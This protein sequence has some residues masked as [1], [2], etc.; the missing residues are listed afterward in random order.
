SAAQEALAAGQLAKASTAIGDL[1]QFDA[2]APALAGLQAEFER[3]QTQRSQDAEVY[4]LLASATADFEAG[5][6]IEPDGDN[7]LEKFLRVEMLRP[8]MG[9]VKKGFIDIGN[10]LLELAD[11]ASA[12]ERFDEAYGYLDIA[13]SILPER[14]EIDAARQYVDNRKVTYDLKMQRSGD[15]ASPGS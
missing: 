7:A 3:L 5:R 14:E 15:A 4:Q 6:I 12:A 8:G 13:K 9:A 1:Q 2:A 11:Q 10:H